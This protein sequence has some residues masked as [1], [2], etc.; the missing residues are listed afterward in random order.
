MAES[1]DR[2]DYLSKE[3]SSRRLNGGVTKLFRIQYQPIGFSWMVFA[4]V[5][6]LTVIITSLHSASASSG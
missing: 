4:A 5:R 2:R 3:A 1:I 6:I